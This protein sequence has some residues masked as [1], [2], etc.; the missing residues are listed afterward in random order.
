MTFEAK[1]IFFLRVA[2]ENIGEL[3]KPID[4]DFPF[5]PRVESNPNE[6]GTH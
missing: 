4:G 2:D 1:C 3:P 5:T 6:S